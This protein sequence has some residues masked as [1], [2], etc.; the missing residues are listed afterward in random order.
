MGHPLK[1]P[2]LGASLNFIDFHFRSRYT[3]LKNNFTFVILACYDLLK[4][5]ADKYGVV[6]PFE[7]VSC[8][9]KIKAIIRK[10]SKK[11]FLAI[12]PCFDALMLCFLLF[13]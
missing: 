6:R 8:D 4:F 2:R 5:C 9:L 13:K 11:Y 3:F 12:I 1:P 10:F 7:K